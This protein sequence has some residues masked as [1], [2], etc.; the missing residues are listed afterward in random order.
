[1][2]KGRFD[3]NINLMEMDMDKDKFVMNIILKEKSLSI[4]I[5]ESVLKHTMH[6]L[7]SLNEEELV[8]FVKSYKTHYGATTG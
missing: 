5:V 8:K 6:G 1:M 3:I 7:N 2:G 4:E